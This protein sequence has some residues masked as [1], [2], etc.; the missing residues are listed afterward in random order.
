[1][2][3]YRKMIELLN[4]LMRLRTMKLCTKCNT[5]KNAEY[6]GKRSKAKDGLQVWCKACM[7]IANTNKAKERKEFGNTITRSSKVCVVCGFEKPI[8]SFHRKRGYSAD[9]YGSYC[10][11]CWSKKVISNKQKAAAHGK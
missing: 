10:K 1:M 11:P 9:G 7:N 4:K 2:A 5:L 6:F 8:T 3:R